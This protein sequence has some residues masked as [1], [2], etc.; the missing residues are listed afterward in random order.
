MKKDTSACITNQYLYRKGDTKMKNYNNFMKHENGNLAVG[1][2]KSRKAE[3]KVMDLCERLIAAGDEEDCEILCVDVDRGGS[4][5]ID[6]PQLDDIYRAMEMSIINHLFIRSF[7]DI[8]EDMED[9]VSFMQFAN[10]NKVQ[11]HVVSV[12]ADKEM[13]EASEPWD[14]G[15]GC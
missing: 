8:S 11:I 12:E 9:L 4:R 10:D 2:I 6:R 13:K 7:D 15:A 5:D 1:F 14:G 3:H